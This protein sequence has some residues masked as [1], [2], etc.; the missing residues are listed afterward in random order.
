VVFQPSAFLTRGSVFGGYG[1]AIFGWPLN[2]PPPVAAQFR[3]ADVAAELDADNTQASAR[4]HPPSD[5]QNHIGEAAPG[6][7]CFA[8]SGPQWRSGRQAPH[9]PWFSG[10]LLNMPSAGVMTIFS[11][12]V[13]K[14]TPNSEKYVSF[15]NRIAKLT[16]PAKNPLS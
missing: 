12:T 5:P 1:A 3:L 13:N 15:L 4:P 6:S 16:P 14:L 9:P 11:H 7:R 2:N 8:A 10:A